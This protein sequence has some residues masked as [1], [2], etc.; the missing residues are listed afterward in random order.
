M[1]STSHPEIKAFIQNSER[2]KKEEEEKEKRI[3]YIFCTPMELCQHFGD[4]CRQRLWIQW[5]FT[6]EIKRAEF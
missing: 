3:E 1:S 4:S 5:H 2:R 6:R